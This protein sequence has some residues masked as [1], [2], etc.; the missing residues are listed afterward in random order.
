MRATLRRK[1]RATASP[2]SACS[3]CCR[4][5]VPPRP[6]RSWTRPQALSPPSPRCACRPAPGRNGR[7]LPIRYAG[8]RCGLPRRPPAELAVLGVATA[9]L[10][11]LADWIG[12]AEAWFPYAAPLAG[13]AVCQKGRRSGHPRS[14]PATNALTPAAVRLSCDVPAQHVA[15]LFAQLHL[16]WLWPRRWD[17]TVSTCGNYPH[18]FTSF[19]S[20]SIIIPP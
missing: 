11:V 15:P 16:G 1:T 5:S 4:A 19:A 12:S 13:L 2:G 7:G 17:G 20:P 18:C 8:C 6:A 3:S 14:N 9:G 10:F